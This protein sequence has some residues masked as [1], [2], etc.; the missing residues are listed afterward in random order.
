MG[1]VTVVV[2][3]FAMTTIVFRVR[4]SERGLRVASLVGVPR[5]AV[6]LDD[7]ESVE[8]VRVS[9]MADFGGWGIR[10]GVDGRLGVVL[11]S[12]DAIQVRRRSGRTLVV[13]VEDAQTGAGLLATLVERD[14]AARKG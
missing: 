8:V 11:R 14:A 1:L 10:L 3:V 2:G 4:V 7:V 9:P 6:P 5:F 13:T 12:G